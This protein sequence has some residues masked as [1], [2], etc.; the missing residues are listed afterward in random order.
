MSKGVFMNKITQVLIL[1]VLLN[2]NSWSWASQDSLNFEQEKSFNEIVLKEIELSRFNLLFNYENHRQSNWLPYRYFA[3]QEAS[4]AGVNAGLIV[5]L[6]AREEHLNDPAKIHPVTLEYSLMPQMIGQ[7]VGGIE[8]VYELFL[9]TKKFYNLKTKNIIPKIAIKH[10]N[11]LNNEL[12]SLGQELNLKN[13]NL[14][15]LQEVNVQ[16]TLQHALI[17]QY[18]QFH[19]QTK[20]FNIFQN[21]MFVMDSLKNTTG[22]LGNLIGIISVHD[23]NPKINGP[24]FLLTTLSGVL[25]ILG[26]IVSRVNRVIVKTIVKNQLKEREVIDFQNNLNQF[27]N[28]L[29]SLIVM[30]AK[31]PQD[32]SINQSLKSRLTFYKQQQFLLQGDL[33]KIIKQNEKNKRLAHIQIPIATIVG[34]T[35]IALG[36]CGMVAG[37]KYYRHPQEAQTLVADGSIPF[38]CGTGIAMVDNLR[39]LTISQIDYFKNKKINNLPSMTYTNYLNDLD[40]IETSVKANIR[41]N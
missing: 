5:G 7:F 18:N 26:P 6:V 1:L 23:R 10:V 39:F 16:K 14:I 31:H 3:G 35:K 21:S 29:N 28:N 41:S 32:K 11:N 34:S 4:A 37:F 20:A 40:K 15:Q 22:A 33:N 25:I 17:S 8:P 24:A 2:L 19:L 13:S 9:K 38:I 30:V 12:N 27:N 36:V